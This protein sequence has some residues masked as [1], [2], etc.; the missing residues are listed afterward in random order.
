VAAAGLSTSRPA[1]CSRQRGRSESNSLTR[2]KQMSGACVQECNRTFHVDLHRGIVAASCVSAY[3]A[4]AVR[5]VSVVTSCK[6]P[7]R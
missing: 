5:I 3:C 2:R 6:A 1:R 7:A 4:S